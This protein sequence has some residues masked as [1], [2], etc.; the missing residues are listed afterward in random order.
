MNGVLYTGVMNECGDVCKLR[1][2]VQTIT[3][4]YTFNVN[5][6]IPMGREINFPEAKYFM[7]KKK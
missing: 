3:Q 5:V 7:S 1:H 6:T 4:S 2:F